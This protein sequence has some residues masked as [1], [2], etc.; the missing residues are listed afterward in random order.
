MRKKKKT[1]KSS[2]S[3][4]GT[5]VNVTVNPTHTVQVGGGVSSDNEA[6][7]SLRKLKYKQF[8]G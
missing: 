5:H 1:V 7:K 2:V 6:D 8:K 3:K 4:S